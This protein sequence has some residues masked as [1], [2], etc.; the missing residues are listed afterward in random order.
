M[1][2]PPRKALKPALE[3]LLVLE[4]DANAQR[5]KCAFLGYA[6][7]FVCLPVARRS[8]DAAMFRSCRGLP[9]MQTATFS[10]D[11]PQ[12]DS[13][14]DTIRQFLLSF[15][16]N[17]RKL[18]QPGRNQ[19]PAEYVEGLI[20]RAAKAIEDMLVVVAPVPALSVKDALLAAC[21]NEDQK[22]SVDD[23]L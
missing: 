9:A 3:A 18:S 1:A 5:V 8:H 20:A 19:L 2:P 22:E 7:R 12:S 13:F 15:N 4:D 21:G 23:I 11:G 17:M 16:A 10:V 6:A 14:T